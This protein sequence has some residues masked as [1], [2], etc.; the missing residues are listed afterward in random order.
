MAHFIPYTEQ[1]FDASNGCS[2]PTTNIIQRRGAG[3]SSGAEVGRPFRDEKDDE[4]STGP[5]RSRSDEL[6]E[7]QISNGSE[8]KLTGASV[9]PM[10]LTERQRNDNLHQRGPAVR[11]VVSLMKGGE[12]NGGIGRR[13]LTVRNRNVR[14]RGSRLPQ[15]RSNGPRRCHQYVNQVQDPDESSTK[16]RR[17]LARDVCVRQH[18]T[19][20]NPTPIGVPANMARATVI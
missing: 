1:G 19:S 3:E 8:T 13:I 14:C 7:N 20:R 18:R 11:T 2:V 6:V 16:S 4:L 9:P 10:P 17:Q 5:G 12:R 15:G